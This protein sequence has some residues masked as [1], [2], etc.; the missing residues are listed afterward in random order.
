MTK[1]FV[2]MVFYFTL[3]NVA[4]ACPLQLEEAR[5]LV[6]YPLSQ[7]WKIQS[8]NVQTP[9]HIREDIL[10]VRKNSQRSDLVSHRP[11]G[12]FILYFEFA[13]SRGANSG[14]K[15]LVQNQ[16]DSLGLEFQILDDD[17][18]SD[19]S[20]GLH[21]QTGALYDLLPPDRSRKQMT[22]IGRFNRGCIVF[23]QRRIEHWLNGQMV[24][25]ADLNSDVFL[26]A[27]KHSKFRKIRH[28]AS[29]NSGYILIQNHGDH[30]KFRNI[31][32]QHL[33]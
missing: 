30:V 31:Y 24:L 4:G 1:Q 29:Q 20:R 7:H 5:N 18:H 14:I 19:G 22:P 21:R 9:W 2:A 28:F 10:E 15:Y 6:S 26:K 13:L 8:P 17:H 33:P 12:D 16:I 27:K 3:A 32:I 25:K 23:K 11:Y